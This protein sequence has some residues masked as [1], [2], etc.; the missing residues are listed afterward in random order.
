MPTAVVH[1][2]E[3][4]GFAGPARCFAVD[5]PYEGSQYVTVWVQPSFGE[6]QLPEVAV[7]PATE[8]GASS[9]PSLKRRPGSF[10]LHD[11]PD[12]PERING[13]FWMALLML[14]GY[15]IGQPPVA[16]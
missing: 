11:N 8:T 12:T 13:A 6:F 9:E 16:P 1:I 5:P 4:G 14:G 10:I 15:D 7:I 2:A 3:V